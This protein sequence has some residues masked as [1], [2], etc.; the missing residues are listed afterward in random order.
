MSH[1][2]SMQKEIQDESG[3]PDLGTKISS[4]SKVD[5]RYESQFLTVE[6]Q[7]YKDRIKDRKTQL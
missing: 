4:I 6:S 1:R 2:S 5:I 7:E 3:M